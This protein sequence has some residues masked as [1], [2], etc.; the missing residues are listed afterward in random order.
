MLSLGSL[1]KTFLHALAAML[2]FATLAS[3]RIAGLCN[4]GQ[5]PKTVS[6]CTGVLVPPNP[7]GGGPNRD[8]N[9]DILYQT[10]PSPPHT[11]CQLK[12]FVSAWVDTPVPVWLHG[13]GPNNPAGWYIY[14]TA[15]PVPAMLPGG[16]V[17]TGQEFPVNP[18]GSGFSDFQQWWPVTFANSL[19][20][21]PGAY[22][23][24]YFVVLNAYDTQ[25]GGPSNTGFRVEFFDSSSFN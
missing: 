4:T 5:T 19:P 24:L 20:I 10:L 1:S 21:A 25:I 11:P 12:A 17:P 14:R 18:P 23:Y 6:G 22:A 15:F 3:A 2:L 16:T 8:G 9:W 13:E 7:E